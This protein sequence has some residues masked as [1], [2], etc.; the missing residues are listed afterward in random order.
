MKPELKKLIDLALSDGNITFKEREIIAKKALSLN[1]NV[2]EAMR[3][4]DEKLIQKQNVENKDELS[5]CPNCGDLIPLISTV[6][7]SCDTC[8]RK[9][10][11]TKHK[12]R[13]LK[14]Q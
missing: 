6:C 7:P 9:K 10:K 8:L 13:T 11:K 14:K 3:Y 4:L 12:L 5:S 1:D 2:D